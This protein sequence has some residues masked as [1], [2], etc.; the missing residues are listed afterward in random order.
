M[1]V[2][3]NGSGTILAAKRSP[4]VAQEVNLSEH[5]ICTPPPSVLPT[6]ALKHRGNITRTPKQGYQ[7]LHKKDLCPPKLKKNKNIWSELC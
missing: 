4:G 3:E 1:Y 6:L 2:G 5:I 7:W